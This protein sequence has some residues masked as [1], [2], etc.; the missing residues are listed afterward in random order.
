MDL[1]SLSCRPSACS[2]TPYTWL[3]PWRQK[4]APTLL[5]PG[6]QKRLFFK[7]KISCVPAWTGGQEPLLAVRLDVQ[8]AFESLRP[9][10]TRLVSFQL[11]DGE[12][13]GGE[14]K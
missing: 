14:T 6:G 11:Q 13:W 10:R 3:K 5:G 9:R 8:K 4:S 7:K 12:K 1:V 2:G